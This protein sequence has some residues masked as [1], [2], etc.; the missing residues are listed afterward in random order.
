MFAA[1]FDPR[2]VAGLLFLSYRCHFALSPSLRALYRP[3]EGVQWAAAPAPRAKPDNATNV[4]KQNKVDAPP[5][6]PVPTAPAQAKR[7]EPDPQKLK[8]LDFYRSED[9][10]EWSLLTSRVSTLVTS[11]SFL[12]SGYA[13]SMG[14][15]I[16]PHFTLYFPLLLSVIGLCITWYSYPGITGGA[17]IITLWHKKQGRLFLLNPDESE[18]D[19]EA[20]CPDP[21]MNDYRDGRTLAVSKATGNVPMDPVQANS[22]RFA[23]V[24]PL[25]FG[26]TWLA[27]IGLR[28]ILYFGHFAH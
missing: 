5:E 16:V 8:K 7:A 24:M 23:T 17:Q 2:L 6:L 15:S 20:A 18:A 11:Q 9:M 19:P 10:H 25:L 26:V 1:F 3:A 14:N 13:I 27:L 12:V 22:L 21:A 4:R 28:L